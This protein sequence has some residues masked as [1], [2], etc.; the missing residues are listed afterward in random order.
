MAFSEQRGGGAIDVQRKGGDILGEELIS[1]L[2]SIIVSIILRYA[3][4]SSTLP[5]HCFWH[6]RRPPSSP[7][8]L[9]PLP[10]LPQGP[11]LRCAHANNGLS[12]PVLI[13]V[14]IPPAVQHHPSQVAKCC[15][16]APHCRRG[17]RLQL[18]PPCLSRCHIL[19]LVSLF[20][21]LCCCICH[22]HCRGGG[23]GRRGL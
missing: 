13:A 10:N 14:L 12:N 8:P 7:P 5:G 3:A 22:C 23:G 4:L 20:Y 18:P 15:Y 6:S 1:A 17:H 2:K 21:H 11:L 16:A 19:I 9:R